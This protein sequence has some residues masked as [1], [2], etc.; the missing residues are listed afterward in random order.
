[1][2]I[3]QEEQF[4]REMQMAEVGAPGRTFLLAWIDD[5]PVGFASLRETDPSGTPGALNG[6][7]ALEIV[8]LYSEQRTIGKGVGKALMEVSLNTARQLGKDWIWLGVWEH[9]PRAIAFYQKWG[10]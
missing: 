6:L 1:M 4:T 8:Q 7:P 5:E 10:F 2:R 9:N 3:F